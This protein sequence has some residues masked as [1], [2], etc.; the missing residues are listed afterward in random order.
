MTVIE[1]S[2]VVLIVWVLCFT[3]LRYKNGPVHGF[4]ET[5]GLIVGSFCLMLGVVMMTLVAAIIVI[6]LWCAPWY[7]WFY[8]KLW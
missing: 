3:V 6:G 2:L 5:M 7:E 8:N 1:I 4:D